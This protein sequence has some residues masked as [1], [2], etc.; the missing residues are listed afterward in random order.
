ML[1][2]PTAPDGASYYSFSPHP[3]WRF[4]MVDAYDIS[5]LGW[6]SDHPKHLE[7]NAILDKHNPNEV[8]RVMGWRVCCAVHKQ[9]RWCASVTR[10]R[11]P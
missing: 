11:T 9:Q 8:R 4:V 7:A 5:V 10:Y 3:A 2:I 1:D 6:D